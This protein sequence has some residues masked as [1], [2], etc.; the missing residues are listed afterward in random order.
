VRGRAPDNWL[1]Q[2]KPGTKGFVPSSAQL[3]SGFPS[4]GMAN[5]FLECL[6][7]VD[8][9][10]D[11][12]NIKKLLK[13]PY[14]K[15]PISM[16]VHKVGKS[17]L[18]DDFDI[19]KYLLRR[20]A[21]EWEWIGKFFSQTILQQRENVKDL[22]AVAVRKNSS[23]SAIQERNLV[24]KFLYRSLE[25]KIDED[26]HENEARFKKI[27]EGLEADDNSHEHPDKCELNI[28][29]LTLDVLPPL[30][31]PEDHS[32]NFKSEK[33]ERNLL[34]NFEDMRMLIGSNM[35]IFGDSEHPCVSLR[36]RDMNKPINVLTGMDYWLDNL[37]CQVPEVAMCYHIDGI[38]QKYELIKTEDLPS[39]DGSQFSPKIVRNIA[40]NILSFL[41]SNVAKEGHTYWLFKGKD[42]DIVKLYD[43]TSI[44]QKDK[45]IKPRNGSKE[46]P[47]SP[48]PESSHA[49]NPFRTPVSMLLYRLARNILES[50]DRKEEEGTVRELLQNCVEV[51]DVEK[52]PH[53]ATSAHFLLSELYIPEDTDPAAPAFSHSA[54]PEG[55]EVNEDSD[56][57]DVDNF[58]MDISTLCNLPGI[59]LNFLDYDKKS[60][61]IS[62]TVEGRCMSA[63]KHIENGLRFLSML[64]EKREKKEKLLEKER[65]RRERENLTMSVPNK[66]IPMGYQDSS[67]KGS[68]VTRSVIEGG[69]GVVSGESGSSGGQGITWTEYLK[70]LLLKKS[71]LVY[72]TLSEAS[73]TSRHLGRTLKCV[74]RAANCQSMVESLGG[75]K[76]AK[77][78]SGVLSFALGVAGDSYMG[79]VSSWGE[80]PVYGEEYNTSL[81]A[82]VGIAKEVER[83][84]TELE[85]DWT[86][87]VP[88][89]IQDAMELATT[90]YA[91][92]LEL[93]GSERS[94]ERDSLV[95]RLANVENE[96]G[97]FFMNQ[98]TALIQKISSSQEQLAP[99]ALAGAQ[100]L[101][102]RSR[103][104]LDQGI[105][106]FESISDAANTALLLSN[107]GRLS[108]LAGH[109]AGL[110]SLGKSVEF[111]GEEASYYRDALE[112]YGRALQVLG[113]KRT[114]PSIWSNVTWE[115]SST[116]FTVATLLQDHAPLSTKP[117]DQVEREVTEYMSQALRYIDLETE[118]PRLEVHQQRAAVIH[119]RLASL[120]HHSYRCFP[121]EDC[122]SR[123]LHLKQLSSLHYSKASALFLVVGRHADYL[124]TVLERAGLAEAQVQAAKAEKSRHR[125]ILAVL[126]TLLEVGPTLETLRRNYFRKADE[127]ENNKATEDLAEVAEELKMV[128]TLVKRLQFTLL[129]LVKLGANKKGRNRKCE[130]A[131]ELY[132]SSLKGSMKIEDLVITASSMIEQISTDRSLL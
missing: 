37:M 19:H 116:T 127:T 81:P 131:K 41:K 108:R 95:R 17:L 51:L 71:L 26:M 103:A 44:C 46:E 8:V 65:E 96:L 88:R 104:L 111:S 118:G 20:S 18:L 97:V 43:L 13:I 5:D 60:P 126:D 84:T 7:E 119:H 10:S 121:L 83:Y 59:M 62:S 3:T 48:P 32:P 58:S 35:P 73:F 64:E 112:Y 106:K 36:L 70:F 82:E 91:K 33:F 2:G 129:S 25:N 120:Y 123:K 77:A 24:S 50:G 122:G 69:S 99:T 75:A 30:P 79:V 31:E 52:F 101:F 6:S 14:S 45:G 78:T 40:Q 130:V 28:Q 21:S 125:G 92:A 117:R 110:Q 94:A 80:M 34:W 16:V 54:S 128:E 87:R 23:S 57:E 113:S 38:V 68:L 109:A 114:C 102:R 72:V 12:E 15:T 56:V 90:C 63:L 39:L 74:K 22:G 42:D 66:P 85:R 9:V 49:G 1:R 11:G 29:S 98:A 67:K 100:D 61:P 93:L 55:V 76:E 132:A 86:I 105:A 53:I 4:F 47:T 124:R 107:S 27:V 115:L 89:D